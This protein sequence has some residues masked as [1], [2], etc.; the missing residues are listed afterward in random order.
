M[1]RLGGSG[2][3]ASGVLAYLTMK[4]L[5]LQPRDETR[6]FFVQREDVDARTTARC[7]VYCYY[8]VIKKKKNSF[9]VCSKTLGLLPDE[10]PIVLEFVLKHNQPP[11]SPA[12]PGQS[13][14]Q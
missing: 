10:K 14:P 3:E 13:H 7:K 9:G 11:P 12:H 4:T 6:V 2:G 8:I 5:S 1:G